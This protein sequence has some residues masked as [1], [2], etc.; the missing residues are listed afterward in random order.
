MFLLQV[1]A[2]QYPQATTIQEIPE[3]M[4]KEQKNEAYRRNAATVNQSLDNFLYSSSAP[5]TPSNRPQRPQVVTD[6]GRRQVDEFLGT[7]HKAYG[8]GEADYPEDERSRFWPNLIQTLGLVSF[9]GNT[10]PSALGHLGKVGTAF[11]SFLFNCEVADA[12]LQ[13]AGKAATWGEIG[14]GAGGKVAAGTVG[15]IAKFGGRWLPVLGAVIAGL[16]ASVDTYQLFA[17]EESG[18]AKAGRVANIGC[19]AAGAVLGQVLIPI[20]V[21]GACI[22]AGIGNLVGNFAKSCLT[23]GGFFNKI[24]RSLLGL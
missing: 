17:K 16:D 5:V 9:L 15:T 14:L 8:T 2:T 4:T 22:G 6:P 7:R 12:T 24:G 10:P 20:P 3:G 18:W 13:T 21:I 19:T 23:P 11:N 1:G